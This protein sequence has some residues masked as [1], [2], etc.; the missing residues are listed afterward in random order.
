MD[1]QQLFDE[2]SAAGLLIDNDWKV[3]Q[4]DEY[5]ARTSHIYKCNSVDDLVRYSKTENLNDFEIS[6][7]SHRWRNFKRHEAWLLLIVEMVPGVHLTTEKFHKQQDF[8]LSVGPS[9]HP[10]DLK[11]TRF[12][13][14]VG[15]NLSDPE[16]AK[17]FYEHQSRQGRYHIANRFFVVGNPESALY[18]INLAR[19][20][21]GRFAQSMSAFRHFV[22][23]SDGEFSRAVVLRQNY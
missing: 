23:H 19:Q 9:T 1:A 7:A 10:F 14:S 16:L 8:K 21:L 17:W 13:S 22:E 3:K 20:T 4:S 18:D 12:P 5:D 2:I 6:Y 15:K 11:V